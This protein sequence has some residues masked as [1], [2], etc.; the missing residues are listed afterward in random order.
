MKVVRFFNLNPKNDANLL[1]KLNAVAERERLRPH[2]LGKLIIEVYCDQ[3][4]HDLDI[5]YRK[6]QSAIAG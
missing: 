6:F 3:K 2:T 1:A 5:D 4:I